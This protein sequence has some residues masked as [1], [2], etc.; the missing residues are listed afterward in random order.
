M[1]HIL[2]PFNVD[3]FLGKVVF[4]D[5]TDITYFPAPWIGCSS[6]VSEVV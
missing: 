4:L 1:L 5:I 6:D 2:G 3:D